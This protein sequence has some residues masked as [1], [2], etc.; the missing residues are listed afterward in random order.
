MIVDLSLA[1]NYR[2]QNRS[3]DLYQISANSAQVY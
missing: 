1:D 2:S 3:D